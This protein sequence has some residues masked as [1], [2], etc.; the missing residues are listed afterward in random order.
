M[1][2]VFLLKVTNLASFLLGSFMLGTGLLL[3]FRLPHGSGPSTVLGLTRHEWGDIHLWTGIGLAILIVVH[4]C[5][6]RVWLI[7][8]AAS[9]K[10][11]RLVAGFALGALVIAAPLLIPVEKHEQGRHQ[12]AG[13]MKSESRNGR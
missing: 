6:H 4:L 13:R 2:R 12:Q 5:Q 7:Q 1:S 3:A 10:K 8:A 9:R 11:L